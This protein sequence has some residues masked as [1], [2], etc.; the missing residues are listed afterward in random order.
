MTE[1]NVLNMYLGASFRGPRMQGV[2]YFG[3]LTPPL[4]SFLVS[5]SSFQLTHVSRNTTLPEGHR[6]RAA[7]S[8]LQRESMACTSPLLRCLPSL[9]VRGEGI[10]IAR[11]SMSALRRGSHR[12]LR[13]Q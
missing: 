2:P 12:G 8:W 9:H 7:V 3:R 5:A 1:S 6:F 4:S 11:L 13:P 10:P